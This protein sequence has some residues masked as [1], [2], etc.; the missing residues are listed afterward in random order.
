MDAR[1]LR[2]A[3]RPPAAPRRTRRS[4]GPRARP[5]AQRRD[6]RGPRL[7][8]SETLFCTFHSIPPPVTSFG[9][10]KP[11]GPALK[12]PRTSRPLKGWRRLPALR[13]W[14]GGGGGGGGPPHNGFVGKGLSQSP[15][16]PLPRPVRPGCPG[17]SRPPS[18]GGTGDSSPPSS[19]PSPPLWLVLVPRGRN[20]RAWC[21][22]GFV[23]SLSF[24]DTAN[25]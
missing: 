3:A 12:R 25:F 2:S 4:R 21:F 6:C 14:P 15:S 13:R 1:G 23:W 10:Q 17:K 9:K 8:R 19:P 5:P 22:R 24:S 16:P 20:N 11:P 7:R 18:R